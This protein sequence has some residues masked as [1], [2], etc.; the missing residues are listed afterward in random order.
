MIVGTWDHNSNHVGDDDNI[1]FSNDKH[2]Y[3][4]GAPQI[5]G[6]EGQGA[7]IIQMNELK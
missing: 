4:R 3:R 6:W 2:D 7:I 1:N 5:K